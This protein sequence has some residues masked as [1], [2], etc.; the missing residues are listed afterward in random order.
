MS[1]SVL[2][3]FIHQWWALQDELEEM[4]HGLSHLSSSLPGHSG[5]L[6]LPT[7]CSPTCCVKSHSTPSHAELHRLRADVAML[8]VRLNLSPVM[9]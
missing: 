2:C 1:Y 7:V 3:R 9:L 8:R 4:R 6:A 5:D